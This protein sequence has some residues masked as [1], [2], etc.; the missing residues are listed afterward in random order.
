[1]SDVAGWTGLEPASSGDTRRHRVTRKDPFR[2]P[3]M[4]HAVH[5]ADLRP[6]GHKVASRSLD[7]APQP[8]PILVR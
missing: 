7:D 3:L 6:A 5:S 8:A 1:M 2:P 4:T